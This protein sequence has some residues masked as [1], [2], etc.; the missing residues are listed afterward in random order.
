[1]QPRAWRAIAVHYWHN[2]PG[3]GHSALPLESDE[4]VAGEGESR[5]PLFGMP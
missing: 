1:M 3:A 2:R 5:E 4:E